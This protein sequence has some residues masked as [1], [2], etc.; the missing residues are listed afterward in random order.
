M[1]FVK[2]FKQVFNYLKEKEKQVDNICLEETEKAI[3]LAELDAKQNAPVDT[4]KHRQSIVGEMEGEKGKLSANM[5]YSPYLEFGTGTSVS[6][7][8]GFEELAIQFKG[9]KPGTINLPARPHIIPAA[10][11]ASESMK[12]SIDKRLD[13]L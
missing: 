10:M 8:P 5:E 7:P 12:K 9:N 4:G 11:K 6:I 13:E 2:G 3:R 1:S